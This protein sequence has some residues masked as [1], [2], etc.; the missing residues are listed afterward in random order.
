M[1]RYLSERSQQT[2]PINNEDQE[3]A[4]AL[5]VNLFNEKKFHELNKE[6][7]NFNKKYPDTLD[8]INAL[9]L[10][11]KHLRQFKKAIELFDKVIELFPDVDFVYANAGNL[12]FELG[13]INIDL[14]L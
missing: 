7:L 5:I 9:A 13:K 11:F 14:L 12:Y 2:N 1:L 8:G 6:A 10:S 4:L 3:N